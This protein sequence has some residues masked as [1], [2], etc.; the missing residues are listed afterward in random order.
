MD[1]GAKGVFVVRDPSRN[2]APML[3]STFKT[4]GKAIASARLYVTA[5]GIYEVFLNGTRVGD[6]HYNPGLSQYNLTHFYQTYDVTTLLQAGR[7]RH[8]RGPERRVVERAPQL[9]RHLEPLRRPAV[10]ARQARRHLRRRDVG[11]RDDQRPDVEVLRAT[12]RSS[13]A[14]STSARCTTRPAKP[15]WRA[16]RPRPSR[17]RRGRP[18]STCPSPGTTFAGED[19]SFGGGPGTKIAFDKLSLIGQVGDPAPGVPHAVRQVRQ[20][21]A[22]RR[23]RLRPRPEHRRCTD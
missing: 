6:D 23:V 15:R 1:G 22:A 2:S 13:T 10:A 12:G 11:R 16:G 9:R 20:G 3:R 7:E 17:T 14:A 18:P 19:V 4:S 8:R 21:S 5:R